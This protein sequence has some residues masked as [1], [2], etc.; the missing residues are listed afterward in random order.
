MDNSSLEM[1]VATLKDETKDKE[2]RSEA[3]LA[4][5]KTGT[6]VVIPILVENLRNKQNGRT[7]MW[8]CADAL[9]NFSDPFVVDALI[10]ALIEDYSGIKDSS[11]IRDAATDSIAIIGSDYAVTRLLEL[12]DRDRLNPKDYMDISLRQDVIMALGKSKNPLCIDRLLTILRDP[13]A[14]A[15]LQVATV[16]ALSNFSDVRVVPALETALSSPDEMIRIQAKLALEKI[17]GT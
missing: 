9:A 11:D 12:L 14:N 2:V 16:E 10:D 6:T 13:Q 7:I 4:L 3:A 8:H 15:E 17:E 5:G 1:L